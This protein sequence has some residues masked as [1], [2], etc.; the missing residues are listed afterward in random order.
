MKR[1]NWANPVSAHPLNRNLVSWYLGHP[2]INGNIFY[3]L[4]K[5]YNAIAGSSPSPTWQI[6]AQ[7]QESFGLQT[8]GVSTYSISSPVLMNSTSAATLAGWVY[9]PF[10]N[11]KVFF[12]LYASDSSRFGIIW[13]VDGNLYHITDNNFPFYSFA[14]TGWYFFA[15]VFDG[16]ATIKQI[17]YRNGL[18]QT[19]SSAPTS[20]T[21]LQSDVGTAF[22]IG[23]SLSNT[24][25]SG[26]YDDIRLYNRALSANEILQLYQES[27]NKHSLTLNRTQQ[28][29]RG[30]KIPSSI[31]STNKQKLIGKK[32]SLIGRGSKL[33]GA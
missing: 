15:H 6:S 9:R 19:I 3:D 7:V 12:G 2:D 20:Q 16:N 28:F 10:I 25:Y 13:D 32:F 31:V 22:L 33:I 27:F 24:F 30:Y 23:R 21:S 14:F 17:V 29:W 11:S 5:R 26:I 4:C 1:I 8:D 18:P